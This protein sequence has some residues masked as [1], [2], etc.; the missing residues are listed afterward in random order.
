MTGFKY[1]VSLYSYTDDIGTVMGLDEALEHVAD[2]GAT[3]IEI[4]SESHVPAY[5]QPGTAWIDQWFAQIERLKLVPTN[6]ACWVD[7]NITLTH[8]RTEAE[9]AAQLAQDL[10]L[11][12]LLGFRFIRPKFGVIDEELTPHPIWRGAVERVLDLAED[13]NITIIPE[14]HAPTPIRHPV[15]EAYVDFIQKTGTKRFGLLIDTG[16]FQDRPLPFWPG[17]TPE[18]RKAA[19]GFLDGIKVPVEHLAEVI[20]YVPFI[21]AKFHHIDEN[22]HDHH[23]P[24]ETIVPMLKKLNYTGYLSSEYE[25]VRDPWVAI[26]QVRR[27]HCL[28]R[29]LEAEVDTIHA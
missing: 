4:L 5:P 10:H 26:E 3:G 13:L 7:T 20:D 6:M 9:G 25:G 16:I 11:A 1:G 12:H 17:E 21:Q 22:L 8:N 18:I 23:I 24:W 14:I 15:T 19:L 2:T 29:K 28:I 27:Q